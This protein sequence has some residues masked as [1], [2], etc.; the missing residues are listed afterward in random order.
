MTAA[1]T[2]PFNVLGLIGRKGVHLSLLKVIPIVSTIQ[3]EPGLHRRPQVDEVATIELEPAQLWIDEK[4]N[5]SWKTPKYWVKE[6]M[7][8]F[9]IHNPLL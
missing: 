7:T 4:R 8:W 2:Q 3:I 9:S 5:S 1:A 6:G